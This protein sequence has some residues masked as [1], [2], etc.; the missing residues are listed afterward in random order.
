MRPNRSIP[1][2]TVIPVLSY[3]DVWVVVHTYRPQED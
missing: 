2:S 3:P 1:S